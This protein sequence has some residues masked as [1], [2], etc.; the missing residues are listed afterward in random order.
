MDC[1]AD[2][3][4]STAFRGLSSAFFCLFTLLSLG[5]LNA[6]HAQALPPDRPALPV[7]QL[8]GP[9]SGQAAVLALG[10]DLT[11]VA[12]YYRMPADTLAA[13]LQDDPTARIDSSGRVFFVEDGLRP[14]AQPPER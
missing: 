3:A 10:E 13:L 2:R 4:Y 12:A 1:S 6:A 7:L 8:N 9:L 11:A 14:P 5:A